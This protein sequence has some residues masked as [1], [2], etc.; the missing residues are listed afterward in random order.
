MLTRFTDDYVNYINAGYDLIGKLHYKI[1]VE[2]P[3]IGLSPK[4]DKLYA[5]T[6]LV[7]GIIDLLSNDSNSNFKENE[8]LL[9]CL[10]SLLAIHNCPVRINS[11]KYK[12]RYP[13]PPGEEIKPYI[14]EDAQ[15]V[16][17]THLG[18]RLV[19]M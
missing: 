16:I 7:H 10:K 1:S 14:I 17:V 11:I 3:Y 19:Y 15:T 12:E 2:E 5:Q 13:L 4:L 6:I 18:E 9:A 8:K